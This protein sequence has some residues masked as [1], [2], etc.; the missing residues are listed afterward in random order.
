MK[1]NQP[2]TSD[3]LTDEEIDTLNTILHYPSLENAFDQEQPQNLS[4]KRQKM[5]STVAELERVV[6]RGSK[7]E[8]EKATRIIEAVQTTLNFLDEL[9]KTRENQSA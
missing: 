2:Q 3:N 8:A 6:R 9:E 1:H 4:E 7:A 5:L